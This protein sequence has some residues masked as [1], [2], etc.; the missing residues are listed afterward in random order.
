M[1]RRNFIKTTGLSL[2]ST[3]MIDSLYALSDEHSKLVINLPDEVS[4]IVNNHS[5]KLLKVKGREHWTYQDLIVTLKNTETSL[6]IELQA[7]KIE[8]SSV[9][10]QWKTSLKNFSSILNDQWERTYGDISWH[11]PIETEIKN[12]F[13]LEL[14]TKKFSY[15]HIFTLD[16]YTHI[17]P[18]P[19]KN[20]A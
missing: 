9:T 12:P 15:D 20:L 11:K 14:K 6:A 7:P 17:L 8:L 5:V 1:N 2:A 19:P 18:D 3:L 13:S 4:A 16:G 10:L